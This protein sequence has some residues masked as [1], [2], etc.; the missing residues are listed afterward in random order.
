[1]KKLDKEKFWCTL[2]A[3]L[4]LAAFWTAFIYIL[5]DVLL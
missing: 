2:I 4:L 5:K 3:V 1:M